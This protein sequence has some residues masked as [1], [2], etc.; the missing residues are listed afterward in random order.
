MQ[1]YTCTR[2]CPEQA[3]PDDFSKIDER[4]RQNGHKNFLSSRVLPYSLPMIKEPTLRR[5]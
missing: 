1:C 2:L 5:P 4:L 3:I